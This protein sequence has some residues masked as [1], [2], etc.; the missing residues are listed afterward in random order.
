[1][2]RGDGRVANLVFVLSFFPFLRIVPFVTAESQPLAA[3]IAVVACFALGVRVGRSSD[4]A[5]ALLFV[6][7]FYTLVGAALRSVGLALT[8]SATYMLPIFFF[9]YLKDR[10]ALIDPG[11][12]VRM[13]WFLV[14]VGALEQ[15]R[16]LVPLEPVFGLFIPRFQGGPFGGGRGVALLHSEPSTAAIAVL[17]LLLCAVVFRAGR[18]LTR[19]AFLVVLLQ[20]AFLLLVNQSATLALMLAGFLI[21]L[22]LFALLFARSKFVIAVVV[23]VVAALA[24]GLGAAV[25]S[26]S[27]SRVAGL[28]RSGTSVLS[29]GVD[30]VQILS[31]G[32][33]RFLT[34]Y[35]GY[36]AFFYSY[37]LG[38]GVGSFMDTFAPLSQAAGIDWGSLSLLHPSERWILVSG[39]FFKPDSLGAQIAME[40]GI[41][42]LLALVLLVAPSAKAAFRQARVW[43]RPAVLAVAG[44]ALFMIFFYSYTTTLAG[45]VI[46]SLVGANLDA[47]VRLPGGQAGT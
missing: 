10:A 40:T 39:G 45:W 9:A 17:Q 43:H 27:G 46:L 19:R 28:F 3:M 20:C 29:S 24:V 16:L 44:I 41:V 31:L 12:I 1:V 26:G 2:T 38:L 37:G 30:P 42:G 14:I 23:V 11:I 8:Q 35:L 4:A 34:V 6:V 21:L 47:E 18:A 36:F 25:S 13:G 22:G 5:I 15:M 32:G 7:I 33:K